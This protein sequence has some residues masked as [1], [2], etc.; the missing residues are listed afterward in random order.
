MWHGHHAWLQSKAPSAPKASFSKASSKSL[1][2]SKFSLASIAFSFLSDF[3]VYVNR[4][5][6]PGPWGSRFGARKEGLPSHLLFSRCLRVFP[7]RAAAREMMAHS[8][9]GLVGNVPG[10]PFRGIL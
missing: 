2:L 9:E 8:P 10:S 3:P 5:P 1:L 7:A 4:I 6:S